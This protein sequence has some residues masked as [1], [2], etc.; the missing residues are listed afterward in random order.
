MPRTLAATLLA[1]LVALAAPCQAPD[2][3][4][5][6]WQRTLADA[7]D[8]QAATGRPILVAL[9]NTVV[10]AGG[11]SSGVAALRIFSQVVVVAAAAA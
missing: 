10:A 4:Q 7:L 11:W 9:T 1:L 6:H 5:V 3:R 2:G 8:L